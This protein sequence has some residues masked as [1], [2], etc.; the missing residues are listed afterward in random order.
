MKPILMI[1][2]GLALAVSLETSRAQADGKPVPKAPYL[3][4]VPDY[5]HWIVTFRYDGASDAAPDNGAA[6]PAS[7]DAPKPPG[8]PEGYPASIDTIKTGLLRGVVLTF[9]DGSTKQ[10]TCQG[11][12]VL[13]STPKGPQI[14]AASSTQ[15]PYPFYSSG[16]V[17]LDGVAVNPSTFKGVE[18]YKGNPAFRYQ[19]GNSE[20]WVD[21]PSMNPLMV[22]HEGV[23]VSYQFLAAPPRPFAI[24]DDQADLLQK[25]QAAD[26]KARTLR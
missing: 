2:L 19:S 21:I 14:T 15:N 26:Q 3:A 7:T 24:P 22:R 6:A 12:W 13:S 20:V 5:G 18:M 4:P 1:L 16:F 25:E 17:L 9:G 10:Y 11:D 8:A 23:E